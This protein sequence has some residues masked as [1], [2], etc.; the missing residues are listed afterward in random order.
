MGNITT[1]IIKCGMKLHIYIFPNFNGETVLCIFASGINW[2]VPQAFITYITS[3]VLHNKYIITTA[4][5]PVLTFVID[6]ISPAKRG[7]PW[8]YINT[9]IFVNIH[10]FHFEISR[11]IIQTL[12]R[13][14]WFLQ[15]RP[16]S[17]RATAG[18]SRVH[19]NSPFND[20]HCRWGHSPTSYLV[21]LVSF[22]PPPQKD[23]WHM[24]M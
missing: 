20:H 16:P 1:S 18:E 19:L 2:A 9:N 7:H 21:N 14:R 8:S 23:E 22:M 17:R 10:T 11:R 3:F 12:V 15:Q 5:L 13:Y 6:L 4:I 24:N